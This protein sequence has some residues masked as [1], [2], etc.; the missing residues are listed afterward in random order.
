RD[1]LG[2]CLVLKDGRSVGYLALTSLRDEAVQRMVAACA[3][4]LDSAGREKIRPVVAADPTGSSRFV[5]FHTTR[6]TLMRT[7]PVKSQV[8]Y[9]LWESTWEAAFAERLEQLPRVL[10]YVKNN[11]LNFEVPYTFM[12]EEHMYRPDFI[13]ALDD[14]RPDPLYVVAEIKGF[15]GPDAEAKRDTLVKLWKPAVNNDGR[16]GRWEAVEIKEPTDM[17]ASFTA[18]ALA[19]AD[20]QPRDDGSG[21]AWRDAARAGAL[22]AEIGAK[23]DEAAER[24]RVPDA[25]AA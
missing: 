5:D 23:L 7:D 19:D 11:G 25:T 16:W 4:T 10:G 9:V 15:R 18:Q 2:Q 14:G 3:D 22:L 20:G 6:I 24:A 13:V 12:G 1:W 8:S 21:V 17:M